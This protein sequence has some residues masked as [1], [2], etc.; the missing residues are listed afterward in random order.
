MNRSTSASRF[1][2]IRSS[3]DCNLKRFKYPLLKERRG[4]GRFSSEPNAR[5]SHH[6]HRV[7]AAIGRATMPSVS[8]ATGTLFALTG[9][10][11]GGTSVS[12]GGCHPV[13]PMSR[14]SPFF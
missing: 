5:G 9:T 1:D 6:L 10:V 3:A 11:G 7:C 14:S 13:C 8:S 2:M 12:G 4:E